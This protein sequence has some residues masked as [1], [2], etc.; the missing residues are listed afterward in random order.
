MLASILTPAQRPTFKR[1]EIVDRV[2]Y[3]DSNSES[4]SNETVGRNW[5][6]RPI[7]CMKYVDDCLSV[8]KLLFRGN[9]IISNKITINAP[10]TQAHFRTVESNATL[11]G[12]KINHN[13][14]KILC[15]SAAK[16]YSCLLY[17]SPSPRDS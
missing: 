8:D 17:T 4:D 15:I 7:K 9:E 16:S 10:E 6:K 14:T 5:V 2:I 11:R 13:K 3:T 12:M 1:L